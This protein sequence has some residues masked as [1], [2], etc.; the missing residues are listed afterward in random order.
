MTDKKNEPNETRL[1]TESR[2]ATTDEHG[3]R[4]YIHPEDITG[5]W[6]TLRSRFYWFLIIL[7]LVLP[8]VYIDGKQW[9]LLNISKRE[10]TI[11][12]NIFYGHDGPLL[13]FV[14]LGFV[15]LMAFITSI[16]G[17]VWCGWACPQTVFIDALYRKAE[18]L[19]EGKARQRKDL[20][21]QPWNLNKIVKKSLKWISFILISL[22]ITHSFLGYFV[23][24]RE[25]FQISLHNPSDNWT[26]FITML[27][28]SGI[29]L[30]DFGWFKE[31]FCIIACPYGRFQSVSMDDNS[32]IVAYD[33]NRGEPRREKGLPAD[34]EGDCI[35]C[36]HCVKAC[37]TGIDIRQG[38]QLECIACTMCID[39]CDNIM[40]KVQKPEG[41]IRYTTENK[42]TGKPA[43]KYHI[44]SAF[45]LI[46][47]GA[48]IY[49]LIFSL[50]SR[51]ELKAQFLRTS[52]TP[53]QVINKNI[54]NPT[55]INHYTLKISQPGLNKIPF[56][57]IAGKG[58][59][60]DIVL[61]MPEDIVM[62]KEDN[63]KMPVFFKFKKNYLD[64][65]KK[66]VNIEIINT[67]NK[68]IITTIEVN[69][70]GPIR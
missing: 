54:E 2:L 49:G 5:K 55:I 50:N 26:L 21:N 36:N 60:K 65:G 9:I 58:F 53:Y 29:L 20:D 44:R 48:I 15:I 67:E 61:S 69:L 57:V 52:K 68:M 31:Q 27:V 41:L 25:L 51:L 63:F 38:T 30:F 1:A 22:H 6:K 39:A 37:P 10:F 16:W 43:E 7:Y 18:R 47:L 28:I 12:G 34:K 59:E 70:V 8:W 19:I 64:L 56:K 40:R 24:T 4:V 66:K 11:F 23:G 3:S 46:F 14:V 62:M 33:Y 45:Y 17:R 32:L 35:N 13:L 42:L